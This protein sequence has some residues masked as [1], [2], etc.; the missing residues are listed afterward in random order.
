MKCELCCLSN[1]AQ[2]SFLFPRKLLL[3]LYWQHKL[4]LGQIG[5]QEDAWGEEIWKQLARKTVWVKLLQ[6]GTLEIG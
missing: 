2:F 1:V 4:Y 6:Q 5:S 3:V